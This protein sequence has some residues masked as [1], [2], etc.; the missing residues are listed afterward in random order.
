MI[1]ISVLSSES[2]SM[3]RLNDPAWRGGAVRLKNSFQARERSKDLKEKII[4][5]RQEKTTSPPVL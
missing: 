1:G 4:K 5:F 2:E 3:P